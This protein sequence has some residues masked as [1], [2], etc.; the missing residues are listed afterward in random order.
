M[1]S[2]RYLLVFNVENPW[3]YVV[4]VLLVAISA[5]FSSA[6]TAFSSC[7]I[8]RLKN[9]VEDGY[10]R[11]KK[12]IY[13]A[14]NF[15][16]AITAILIGNNIA[17]IALTS[18][19]A[20]L[21]L[22][23]FINPTHANIVNTLG[24]TTIILIFGEL[25]PKS[26]AK[27]N[28][29]SLAVIYGGPMYYLMILFKPF[30]FILQ[31]ISNSFHRLAKSDTNSVSFTDNELETLIDHMEEEGSIEE[32]RAEMIQSVL[33]LNDTDVE[34]IMTPRV[35]CIMISIDDTIDNLKQIFVDYQLTRIP[36]YE[37]DKDRVIGKVHLKD[38]MLK[39]F[40]DKVTTIK[41]LMS[42]IHFVPMTMT[43]DDLIQDLQLH[44]QH[45]AI[46]TG[47]YGGTAGIVTME[48]ALEELVG[49][50]FD[51]HD[52]ELSEFMEIT[53][54]KY[55]IHGDYSLFD[56]FEEIDLPEPETEYSSVNGFILELLEA[57]P[58]IGD[59]VTYEVNTHSDELNRDT[60]THV[61]EF[62]IKDVKDHRILA[63][64]LTKYEKEEL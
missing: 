55:Y 20:T 32:D 16:R 33:D 25:L 41:D 57:Y 63:V 9:Y 61:L 51:E 60:I 19:G 31:P 7:N 23:I 58:N 22:N 12:A 54:G 44:Q 27:V 52:D 43:V 40:S 11:A 18:I 34:A 38:F 28:A 56:L 47:E 14:E 29:D 24:I 49:E 48:D 26:L 5:F 45:M 42:D 3:L 50:I 13:V 21:L 15:E 53:D 4:M 35:D 39:T 36:V 8:I 62:T 37:T 46:V 10:T 30:I 64:E 59:I 6:E 17:N 2:A 1:V